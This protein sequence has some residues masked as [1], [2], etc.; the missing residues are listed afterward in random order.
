MALIINYFRFTQLKNLNIVPI[1][2]VPIANIL[3]FH[4]QFAIINFFEIT[5]FLT[6]IILLFL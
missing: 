6:I 3:S 1:Y 2:V 5:N 4:E